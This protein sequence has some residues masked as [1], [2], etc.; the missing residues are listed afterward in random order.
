MTDA[1]LATDGA[2][3]VSSETAE[4]RRGW[5]S[6]RYLTTFARRI[7]P[8]VLAAAWMLADPLGLHA[9]AGRKAASNAPLTPSEIRQAEQR[10][11]DLGY[12]T[13]RVDGRWDTAF[14]QALIAFQKIQARKVTGVL[15][16]AEWAEILRALPPAPR[17]RTG[18]T[19]IEVDLERQVL[20]MVDPGDRVA[21]ILP[22]SSGTG[23]PFRAKGWQ[24][25]ADTPCGHFTVFAKQYGWKTSPLGEMHN[26]MY[27]VGG[28]A[29]HGS[30]SVPP[31]PA[32]HGC[33][34]I[35]MFASQ[36]LTKLIP[37]ETPVVVYGCKDDTPALSP[38]VA[39]LT[40][41]STTP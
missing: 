27:L 39:G 11:S 34:R 31:K 33:I 20:F 40:P 12:W 9:A 21:R 22:I 32:S 37:K 1:T 23:K 15:T 38:A 29:I 3:T 8:A 41:R 6:L 35:P 36:H 4:R 5:Y 26:P 2:G 30:E 7:A 13:G 16:R 25:T 28:I 10:L 24:G 14:R 18:Q 17:E 19:H